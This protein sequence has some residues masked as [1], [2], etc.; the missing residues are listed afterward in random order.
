MKIL[1]EIYDE[2]LVEAFLFHDDYTV[3][4]QLTGVF[5]RFLDPSILRTFL[6]K[7]LSIFTDKQLV[8][9]QGQ[10]QNLLSLL[11]EIRFDAT[12]KN[13]K[14]KEDIVDSINQC[15]LGLNNALISQTNRVFIEGQGWLDLCLEALCESFT[16]FLVY[17]YLQDDKTFEEEAI[18]FFTSHS[19]FY[20]SGLYS[21]IDDFP[22]L[23][24]EVTFLQKTKG[25]VTKSLSSLKKKPEFLN[26]N[27]RKLVMKE[28]K[29]INRYFK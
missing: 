26:A 16:F 24:K 18:P 27:E 11:N 6:S 23:T 8:I 17:Y 19:G 3:L 21:L 1:Q 25:V 7:M 28:L 10:K 5:E 20:I 12:F 4:K 14:E 22:E 2:K 9:T 29:R 15:I 13:S